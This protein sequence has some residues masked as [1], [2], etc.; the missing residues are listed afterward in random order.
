VRVRLV[1]E[2]A[3]FA[4][5]RV[6]TLLEAG[7]A[8][9]DP[10][11]PVFGSCGGCA[12]QHVD[13]PAQLEAKLRILSD[14]LTRIGKLPLPGSLHV[15][16]S[17]SPWAYRGRARVLAHQGRVGFRRRRSHALCATDRCP[18][19]H[20]ALEDALRELARSRP[21]DGEWEL[22]LGSD[23]SAR[24][25]APYREARSDP[26]VEIEVAGERLEVSPHVFVQSNH[27]LLEALVASV[28]EG[29]GKGERAI[30]LYAG[31]G[32]FSLPLARRFGSVVAV[33]SHEDAVRDLERNRDRAGLSNLSVLAEP[34]E[35][36]LQKGLLP[37]GVDVV[38]LDPPRRGLPPGGV[39]GL[40]EIAPH[41]IV[42]LS[43]DPATCARDL[44]A[45]VDR[46]YALRSV[47]GFDLFPQTPHVE[48]LAVLEAR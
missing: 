19:L 23:A 29:A 41:R 38:V 10:V 46:G 26:A 16:P 14:A 42:M 17:P 9:R 22:V 24:V 1:D 7:P 6:E 11:C 21:R 43:C 13:Y 18:V 34:V 35:L 48:A 44:A 33:E 45:L 5:A 27:L 37:E 30:E 2:Q 28:I 36:V 8:R 39:D 32:F 15:T 25:H 20:P 40:A 47:C 12:W 3:R 31:A 4:R